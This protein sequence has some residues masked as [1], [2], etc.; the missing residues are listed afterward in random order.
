GRRGAYCLV[1]AG[2]LATSVLTFTRVETVDGLL[3]VMPLYGLFAIGGFGTFA[4]YLPELFPT[5]VRP[6]RQGLCWNLGRVL[7]GGGRAA[8]GMLV[9]ASGWVP[10]AALAVSASYLVGLVAIW[11]GPETRGR[12][13]PD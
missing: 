3:R 1:A 7:T 13:L 12:P 9:V 6:T 5:H 2:C 4:A 10:G 8:S 11:L